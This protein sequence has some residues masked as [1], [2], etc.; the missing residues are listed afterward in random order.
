MAVIYY[1]SSTFLLFAVGAAI[2]AAFSGT[3]GIAHTMLYVGL[4]FLLWPGFCWVRKRFAPSNIP[5]FCA[6]ADGIFASAI[7]FALGMA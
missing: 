6:G 3:F 2:A 5:F 1:A 7:M 4:A